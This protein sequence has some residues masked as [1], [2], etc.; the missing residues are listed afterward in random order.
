MT[1]KIIGVTS[2]DPQA[3][4]SIYKKAPCNDVLVT[5]GI[6]QYTSAQAFSSC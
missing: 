1:H 2:A 3:I 4:Y 6:T 5:G